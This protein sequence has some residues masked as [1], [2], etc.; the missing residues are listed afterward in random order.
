[1]AGLHY[2][3]QKL[4]NGEK[5]KKT[6]IVAPKGIMSDWGKEIGNHTTAKALYI[7]NGLTKKGVDGKVMKHENGRNLWGQ[8]GTEQE[9]VSAKSF[10]KNLEKHA[11]ED[12]DFHIVSYDT[13]MRNREHFANSGMYDNIVID[14]VHAFKNQ[15]GK[16]GQ[17]LAETTDKFKNVWGLSGTPMENDAR[18]VWSLVDTITGG[19]H[20]LGTLK[21]FQDK[22]MKKDKN[23]KLVG[24]K[25]EMAEKLGDILANIVQFR[26]GADVTY[27]DGSKIEFPHLVG[28]TS[29]DQPNPKVDF[30]GN[31]VD[32]SRDHATTDYYG[33]KHS[34]TDF[35]AGTKTVTS[36]NGE[37]YEVQTFTPKNLDPATEAMY[38]TYRQLQAKYLPESKLNELASAAASGFDQAGNRSDK[39]NYLT[40][41]QKLQKFLNA[42]LAHKMYVPGGNAI[43]SDETDAQSE[44]PQSDKGGGL[45]PYDPK[46]GEGHYIID[47]N[48]FKRYFESDGQGG[49][50]RNPDGSPRLL[51]PLHEDNPKAQYL[52]KRINQYLSSLQKENRER[53]ARGEKPLVPKVV[54][55]SSYT[56]FGTDIVDNVLKE[57][58]NTHP[59]FRDLAEHGYTDLGQ[60]RFTGDADDREQTKVGFRGNKKDYLNNQ[61]NLWAT[62]VSPAGK[63][64]VDFGNA[65][66]MFHYDQDWN[67]Q[68]M[69]QF[70]ARVRRSDSATTHVQAGR[71]NAVRVESLHMPG[72]VEDFMFNAQD[73]KMASIKQVTDNTRMAER[74]PKLGET[75]SRLG[76]GHRGFTSRKHPGA[77]PKAPTTV[78]KPTQPVQTPAPGRAG[79]D[80]VLPKKAAAQ[81]DK[82]LK[83]VILL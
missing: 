83:L 68:K 30:I 48:G 21:E 12:H 78:Q 31:M 54:V 8:D 73:S 64:G 26:S 39:S 49:F 2:K 60:G 41:M 50:K 59:I 25:P 36:K 17:S 61:G 42:P 27:N 28:A 72:T 10:L 47:E 33:T 52:K 53:V 34:V 82:A 55:K 24:V 76:Y 7:G 19:K 45:K 35:E 6:L 15:K 23:G 65:H 70:T 18:E 16:R 77:K 32:R 67:P 74:N 44:T 66:I 4:A 63:E 5:P 22:F 80:S 14:E 46:T 38:N 69:A 29:P 13:F 51:P 62:T 81:A 20:E 9:A 56:T 58:R 75:E 79:N 40:A 11:S 57:I 1:V 3:A 43:E 37:T 71:A